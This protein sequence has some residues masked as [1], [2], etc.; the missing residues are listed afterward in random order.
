MKA[1]ERQTRIFQLG[2]YGFDTNVLFE[3]GEL[4]RR[5]AAEGPKSAGCDAR[6]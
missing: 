6:S 4:V 5:I 3:N 1:V 2:V